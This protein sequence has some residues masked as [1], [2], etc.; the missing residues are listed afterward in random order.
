MTKPDEKDEDSQREKEF[1]MEEDRT[2][3][4]AS[5]VEMETACGI[6]QES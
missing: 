1:K 4:P 3:P 5:T 6:D 2:S